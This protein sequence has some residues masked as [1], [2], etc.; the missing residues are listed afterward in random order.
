MNNDINDYDDLGEALRDGR[1]LHPAK[2]YR[3][4]FALND[5]RFRDI[6]VADPVPTGRQILE[7]AGLPGE[8][9]YSLYAI[10]STGDFE[11]VRLDET[12]DLRE[13]G[14]ERF[15]AF[16]TDRDF[17]LT[18]NGHQIEWGN[19]VISGAILNKLAKPGPGEAVYLEVRGGT[20]RLIEDVDLVDLA[21]PGVENFLTAPRRN[22]TY[23]IVINGDPFNVTAPHVTFEQVVALAYPGPHQP[24]TV[25]SMT[26]RRA[27]SAPHAG[28][29][30]AGGSVE[31]KHNGTT[32]N[33]TPTIRS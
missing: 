29:L 3:F 2:A 10:L 1:P 15:V 26:Y 27:A 17:K 16:F 31:V 4:R 5:L 6:L 28:E 8:P 32:F 7:S 33:V 9:S 22:P 20:D 12:F 24:N 19:P 23:E 14:V 18:V 13:K 30:A 11:E 25:F 21:E